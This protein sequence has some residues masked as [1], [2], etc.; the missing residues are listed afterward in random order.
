MFK[1]KSRMATFAALGV[2]LL[3][4]AVLA[5]EWPSRTV[6]VV[7]GYGPGGGTDLVARIVA[8][9]LQEKLKQPF[10]VE[11]K[12]GASGV[13]GA[14]F[15]AKSEKDGYTLYLVNNAHVIVGVMS[16]T[17][18]YDTLASFDPIAQVATGSL[19]IVARPDFPAKSVKDLI[20]LAKASPGKITFA[21]VGNGTTQHFT[22]ELFMQIA[23]I[24]MLH[25]PFRNSPSAI[26]A[27]L[28]KHV[29]MTFDTVSAVLGQI[30]SGELHPLAVTG[31]ERYS[32]IP[33]VPTAIESGLLPEYE[34]TTW[35]GLV[36]PA[37]S[38]QAVIT[39]L[40]G[41]LNDIVAAPNVKEQM[42]KVGAI[43]VGSSAPQFRDHMASEFQRWRAVWAAA[44]TEQK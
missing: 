18:P 35:Y 32:A 16:K 13:V 41:A 40:N 4:G 27:V 42:M 43:A 26:S 8:H 12:A 30:Q 21:S 24:N 34:V 19:A 1:R 6:R 3:P 29:D 28:G 33:Q 15:V 2:S 5:Q 38:P 14:D 20:A 9:G 25:V 11:N 22:A 7:V 17:L 23:G 31:R 36:T 10:I 37:G 44:K 39:K